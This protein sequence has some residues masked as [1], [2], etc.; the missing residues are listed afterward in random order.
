M[1]TFSQQDIVFQ[2]IPQVNDRC[3]TED[4]SVFSPATRFLF[5]FFFLYSQ[6]S[7]AHQNNSSPSF[8][9]DKHLLSH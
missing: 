7:N 5:F 1:K 8:S 3:A 6:D 4:C 2:K 9:P